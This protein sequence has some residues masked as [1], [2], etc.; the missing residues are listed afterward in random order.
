MATTNAI[1]LV[2]AGKPASVGSSTATR[3]TL[4]QPFRLS[5]FAYKARF[6]RLLRAAPPADKVSRPGGGIATRKLA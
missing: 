3:S 2:F 4:R 1:R 6:V 5:E